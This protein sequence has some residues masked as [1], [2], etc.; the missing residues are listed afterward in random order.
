MAACEEVVVSEMS[1]D[2]RRVNHM[3]PETRLVHA[4]LESW[5]AWAKDSEVRAW[6]AV[7][8]LGRI[9]EQ[10][11][12]A[13]QSGKPPI[14]MPADIAATDAAVCRLGDIDKRAIK[15]YYV[16]WQ[17]VENL[18]RLMH[19]RTR[20]YQNVLRRARWRIGLFLGE[21]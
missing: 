9:I 2:K 10:G 14:N 15:L 17:P 1:R 21:I 16:K 8:L 13:G 4:R 11:A 18:A 3:D 7:T 6:P 20:Q 19:M 5:G 12:G